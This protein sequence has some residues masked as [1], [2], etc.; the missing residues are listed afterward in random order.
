MISFIDYFVSQH[1]LRLKAADSTMDIRQFLPMRIGVCD[2]ISTIY[3]IIRLGPFEVFFA[4]A[5]SAMNSVQVGVLSVKKGAN[6]T[7]L[8]NCVI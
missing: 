5:C 4:P 7:K 2:A 1:I 6:G 3:R 8:Q